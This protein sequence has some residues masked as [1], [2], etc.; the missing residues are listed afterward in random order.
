MK[1]CLIVLL[2]WNAIYARIYG[3]AN[4]AGVVLSYGLF[5]RISIKPSLYIFRG[6]E[7]FSLAHVA[8]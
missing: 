1:G 2:L 3:D 4:P 5:S 7:A 8:R 6:C